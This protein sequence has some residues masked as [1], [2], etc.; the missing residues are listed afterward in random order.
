[1]NA[2][3][4]NLQASGLCVR[5]VGGAQIDLADFRGQKLALFF[6][7][8]NVSEAAREVAEYRMAADDFER[9]GVWLIGMVPDQLA[10][11]YAKDSAGH[12]LCI[13]HDPGGKLRSRLTTLSAVADHEGERETEGATYLFDRWGNLAGVWNGAGHARDVLRAAESR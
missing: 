8:A 3:L 5:S 12:H 2:P 13:A 7:P 1:M 9:S 11:G 10:P 4:F 6:C